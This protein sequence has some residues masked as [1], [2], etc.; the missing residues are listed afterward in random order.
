MWEWILVKDNVKG[1]MTNNYQL[2]QKA[3]I[4]Y[5]CAAAR[6]MNCVGGTSSVKSFCFQMKGIHM[7]TG[8]VSLTSL[9]RVGKL[10]D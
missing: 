10:R 5:K 1:C 3:V 6:L 2:F 4:V 9:H 7:I 8:S